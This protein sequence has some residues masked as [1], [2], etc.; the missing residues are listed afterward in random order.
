VQTDFNGYKTTTDEQ[1]KFTFEKVPPGDGAIIRLVST[2]PNSWTWSDSTSVTVQPGATTQVALGDHGAVLNGTVRFEIAPTNAEA[3]SIQGNLSGQ[4]PQQP[5]FDSPAEAQAF[6]QSPEWKAQTKL[7]KH[8][9]FG[10]NPD[11]TFTV[12]D[13]APGSYSL[14]V[15]VQQGRLHPWEHPP[16]AQGSAPVIVPDS[17]SPSSPIDVGEVLLKANSP[18]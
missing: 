15:T 5:S 8:Y 16:L 2:T 13:V 4:M 14:N 17:F 7:V 18:Q 9:A 11:G 1:G 12:D 3:L 10:V 6:Y